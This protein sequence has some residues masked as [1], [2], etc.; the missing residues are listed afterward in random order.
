M[1]G[2]FNNVSLLWVPGHSN[3]VGNEKA[4]ELAR[5]GSQE[6][7]IG[8]EPYIGISFGTLKYH[9]KMWAYQA[10]LQYRRYRQDCIMMKEF[11]LELNSASSHYL[12]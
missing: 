11:F 3:I 6:Q 2:H 5:M 9:M 8:P 4:D 1:H 12:L 10:H 7:F